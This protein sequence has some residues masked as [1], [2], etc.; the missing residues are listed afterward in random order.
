MAMVTAMVMVRRTKTM[1]KKILCAIACSLLLTACGSGN[2]NITKK[3]ILEV[4]RDDANASKSECENV[5]IEKG[6]NYYSVSFDTPSGSYNYKI[7][8]DGI[9]QDRSYGKKASGNSQTTKEEPV[10]EEKTETKKSTPSTKENKKENFDENQTQAINAALANVGVTQSDVTD[11]GCTTSS[12][13]TQYIVTFH[14]NDLL[15][16]ITVDAASFTVLSSITG[17]E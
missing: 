1:R 10:K 11:L 2:L 7:G 16:T 3:D 9:I 8:F 4:A 13:G 14:L 6:S 12:D 15:N 17:G 5:S